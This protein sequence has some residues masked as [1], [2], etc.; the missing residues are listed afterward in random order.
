MFRVGEHHAVRLPR[1]DCY[2]A[3]LM[4]EARWL[5]QLAPN[6]SVRVPDLV[7]LAQP[8][9]LFSRP[10]AV[11]SWVPGDDVP[12]EL[13]PAEQ[14]L[15]A[16][17][18]GEFVSSLHAVGT[19][20][21]IAGPSRWGYRCGEPVTDTI[22]AWAETAADGLTDLFDPRQVRRAWSRIRDVPQAST[23]P[24]WVHTDLSAENLLVGPDGRLVGV[25]DFGGVGVGDPSVDLLYAWSMLD[26]P[27]RAVL[28][29]ASGVDEAAWL[30]ARAWAFVGPGLLTI[31]N[32][33]TSMPS[34]TARLS[35]M[36]EAVADEVGVALR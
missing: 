32:Y 10:W 2:V 25:I 11:V 1:A 13:G 23:Q 21:L 17:T 30:R 33:R 8:S 18:L 29:S 4:K 7:F 16:R 35:R 5:P 31:L 36:V 6:L 15:M 3:D 22:D 24:N 28:G 27:A 26:Q 14:L 12:G 20:G 19:H 34:R 9:P